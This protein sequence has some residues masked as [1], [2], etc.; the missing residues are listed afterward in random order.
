[1]FISTTF[2]CI[3]SV[4][5]DSLLSFEQFCQIIVMNISKMLRLDLFFFFFASNSER[6]GTSAWY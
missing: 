5:S 4:E 3:R 6:G 1:M 2:C